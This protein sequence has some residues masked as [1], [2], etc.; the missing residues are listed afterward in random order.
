VYLQNDDES[1]VPVAQ[2]IIINS[3]GDPVYNGQITKFVTVGGHSMAVYDAD[4]IQLFYFPNVLRYDPD[5]L[6]QRL[7]E[8]DSLEYIGRCPTIAMLRTIE[9]TL[10]LQKIDVMEYAPGYK[11]GGGYFYHDG[12]DTTT[13]DNGVTVIV[14][15]GGKRWKRLYDV[16]D[17]ILIDWAGADPTGVRPSDDAFQKAVATGNGIRLKGHYVVNNPVIIN[18][19]GGFFIKGT[20][21][22]RDTV[23]K[24]NLSA[25]NITRNYNGVPFVYDI[26][27][28]FAFVANDESYV[29]HVAVENIETIGIT[30]DNTQVHFFAPRATYCTFD[31]ILATHGRTFWESTSNGFVNAF[32]N[33]RTAMM[34]K[35]WVVHN[36]NA[37]TLTNVYANGNAIGGESV[38]FEFFDTN[39]SFFSCDCDGLNIGWVS[40]GH[41]NLEVIGSNSE[42]RL[43]VF[44]AKGD[45]SIN[46]HGG[47]HAMTVIASQ[48]S[49]EAA[50]YKAEGNARVNIY[51]AKA[52]KL[53]FDAI[54]ENKF[55][56]IA[57]GSSKVSLF[58]I[59]LTVGIESAAETFS[60]DNVLTTV[61][62]CIVASVDG[63]VIVKKETASAPVGLLDYTAKKRIQKS[64]DF[65]SGIIQTV[66]TISG[67]GY[68]QMM[69][70]ELSLLYRSSGNNGVGSTGGLADCKLAASTRGQNTANINVTNVAL[71]PDF[72]NQTINFTVVNSGTDVSVIATASSAIVGVCSFLIDARAT[73]VNASRSS[74]K[75]S[76][77]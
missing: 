73:L 18:S 39:A 3:G 57:S 9:P 36:G 24:T 60:Y 45:S 41:S 11:T 63:N 23:T 29:R 37:H 59:R 77:T 35:H 75:V 5:Q 62:G 43:R 55:L 68:N 12:H 38:A 20:S 1:T 53:V 61:A 22:R 66:A 15:T 6:F 7:L 28:I 70:A 47:R 74:S 56:A 54:P 48:Q 51:G 65:S 4:D 76:I 33:I 26:P 40:D 16:L 21:R 10:Y 17:G 19:G 34:S 2:P 58:D 64:V 71:S 42:A 46:I 52:H 30:G 27:C 72:G 44:T 13:P 67:I 50:C 25:P 8:P 14:T 32:Y 31:S 49:Q 69:I